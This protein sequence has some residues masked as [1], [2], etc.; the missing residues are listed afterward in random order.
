MAGDILQA[1]SCQAS[2][3]DRRTAHGLPATGTG[4]VFAHFGTK[5]ELPHF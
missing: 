5:K 1:T 2:E 4:A 3:N